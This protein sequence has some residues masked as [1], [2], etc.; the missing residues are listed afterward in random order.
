[1]TE[2]D[3]ERLKGIEQV[4]IDVCIEAQK[5]SPYPFG[6]PRDAGLRTAERQKELFDAG[7][8]KCDG[9]NKK[10]Y[11]ETGKAFDI[12]AIVNGK[13]SW[14]KIALTLIAEHILKVASKMGVKLEWG[15]SWKGFKDMPHFQIK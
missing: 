5:E 11:H 1:M 15:G 4:L 12:Y 6:I 14:N 2:R 7:K 8:S 9:Y 10:S 3:L 13:P